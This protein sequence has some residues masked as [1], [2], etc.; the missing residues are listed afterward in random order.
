MYKQILCATSEYEAL[1][2]KSSL[3]HNFFCH[4]GFA[5]QDWLSLHGLDRFVEMTEPWYPDLI[6]VFYANLNVVDGIITFRGRRSG[7]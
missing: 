3:I 1:S 7:H 6:K 2:P 5:F 4:E